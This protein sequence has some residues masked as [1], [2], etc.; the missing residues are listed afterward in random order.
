[1]K[2]GKKITISRYNDSTLKTIKNELSRERIEFT[3]YESTYTMIVYRDI[4]QSYSEILYQFSVVLKTNF[5]GLSI[6]HR[7]Y[8][9]GNSY[10][11]Y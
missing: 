10:R 1:M 6:Y 9:S 5:A 11:G 3:Y 4:T 8:T 2:N 7:V